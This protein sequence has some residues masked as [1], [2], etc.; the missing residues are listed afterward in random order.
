MTWEAV[1][2]GPILN[3]RDKWEKQ[4]HDR[5]VKL[6]GEHTADEWKEMVAEFA[7]D[8][9]HLPQWKVLQLMEDCYNMCKHPRFCMVHGHAHP[10]TGDSHCA[11]QEG[12]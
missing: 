8:D 5:R 6:L 4:E 1:L 10:D 9:G 7:L 2:N 11:W 12:T 3:A